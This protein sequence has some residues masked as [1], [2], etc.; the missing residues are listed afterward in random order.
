MLPLIYQFMISIY[1]YIYIYIYQIMII[2]L[3]SCVGLGLKKEQTKKTAE[4]W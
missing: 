3:Q 2:M 4:L 1:I